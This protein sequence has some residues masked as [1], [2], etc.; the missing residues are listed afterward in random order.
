M[1]DDD[2]THFKEVK[3]LAVKS[4]IFI[5]AGNMMQRQLPRLFFN[6]YASSKAGCPSTTTLRLSR[7]CERILGGFL[8]FIVI[9]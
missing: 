2:V 9:N 4:S 6:L 1:T 7:S 5:L 8:V 3:V